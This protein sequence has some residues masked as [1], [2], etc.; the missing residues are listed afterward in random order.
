MAALEGVVFEVSLTKE[1]EG[2][3]IN[4]FVH[5][6]TFPTVSAIG[7]T[8]GSYN[9]CAEFLMGKCTDAGLIDVQ[10]LEDSLPNKPIVLAK[11]KGMCLF[12]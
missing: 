11:W 9:A 6:V 5:L 8:N 1:E 7:P 12:M 3:A 2:T 4:D 10:I